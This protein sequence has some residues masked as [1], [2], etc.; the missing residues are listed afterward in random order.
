MS[1]FSYIYRIN[2]SHMSDLLQDYKEYYAVRAGRYA[3]NPNY[4]N[5]FEAEKNLSEAMQSCSELGEFKDR[6]GNLNQLC[7]IALTKDKNLMEKAVCEELKEPIRAAIPERILEKADQ[8]TEV[9]DLINMVNEENTRGMREISL[10]EANRIF[11]YCWMMLDRIETYSQAVVPAAYQADMQNSAKYYAD[12]IREIIK[13]T[14]EQMRLLD[15]AWKHNPDII[16]EYR[17]RRL[18]PYRDEHID[19]QLSK[20]KTIANI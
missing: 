18:L 19:E 2:T 20:Y 8:Y 4:R 11:N 16:K 17:H 5:S 6:L 13:E 1:E 10:D 12:R 3:E 7:A 9:F 15:P 14:E